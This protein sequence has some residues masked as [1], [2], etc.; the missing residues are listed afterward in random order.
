MKRL[1]TYRSSNT[2]FECKIVVNFYENTSPSR[3]NVAASEMQYIT[4]PIIKKNDKFSK[5]QVDTLNNVIGQLLQLVEDNGFID[6][7]HRQSKRSYSY[8]IA[9]T[10]TDISGN[11]WPYPARFQIETR[12]HT[13][14]DNNDESDWVSD[15]LYVSIFKIG[16]KTSFNV[17]GVVE[18]VKQ[19]CEELKNGDYSSLEPIPDTI[20]L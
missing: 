1:L 15:S 6:V 20:N 2:I 5:Y 8:Y 10:P 3:D 17:D 4:D 18:G 9:F 19:I 11:P 16:N 7:T 13:R 14:N 12:D